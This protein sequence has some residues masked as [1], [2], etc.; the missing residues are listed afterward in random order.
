MGRLVIA[1]WKMNLALP[2]AEA[3]AA[4]EAK[5]AEAH[6][7]L[8]VSLAVPTIWL[9][10]LHAAL[11]FKP[12]NLSLCAQ[13]VSDIAEGAYTGDTAAFQVKPFVTYA[14]VGHSERR[15]YHQETG[16]RVA[17]QIKRLVEQGITP[18][19]CFGEMRQSVQSTFS[20]QVTV[21]LGRDLQGLHKD[22]LAACVFAYEPL[23]AIGTGHPADAK[24]VQ[25]ALSHV[26]DWLSDTYHQDLSVLYG[27][28]VTDKNAAELSQIKE[29]DGV[30]VGGASLQAKQFAAI[31]G[32]FHERV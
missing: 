22:E 20:P 25:K 29:L 3:L 28:S 14:L 32:A 7:G 17:H 11:R 16:L 31:C 6:P 12:Q 26:K 9:P 18:V 23:W 27:G 15:R 21:D 4:A 1:N 10:S 5:V 13:S 2:D 19:V 30:L 8:T 24:Y